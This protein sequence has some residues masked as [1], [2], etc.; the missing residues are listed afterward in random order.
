M[1]LRRQFGEKVEKES[2]LHGVLFRT[3]SCHFD[4]DGNPITASHKPLLF[5]S[6]RTVCP[7]RLR[8]GDKGD[9][10]KKIVSFHPPS[11]VDEEHSDC[12]G[13]TPSGNRNSEI[14]QGCHNGTEFLR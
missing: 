5:D 2:N 10:S 11:G 7:R 6:L 1:S 8:A 9:S 14:G 13:D 3:L 4:R 12:F